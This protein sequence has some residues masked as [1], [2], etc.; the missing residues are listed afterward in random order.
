MM[1]DPAARYIRDL[2]AH[3]DEH[4]ASLRAE[5]EARGFPQIH[6]RPEEGLLLHFLLRSAG[7]RRVVEIGTL[8]GYSA[9]WIARALPADGHLISLERNPEHAA[10]ARE[11]LARA[12]LDG[13][14]EIRL[15]MALDLLQTLSAEGPFDAVFLDADRKNYLA[16]LSWVLDNLR[17]GG[18][19]LAHN[20]FMRG[21]IFDPS[22]HSDPEVKGMLEFTRR[23]AEDPRLVSL[24]IPMGD[25][26]VAALRIEA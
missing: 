5:S 8:A 23:I 10:L 1:D 17:V 2:F 3:D 9:T 18:L 15:G 6:L 24:V 13:R 11:Y 21:R 25:G 26:F 16:Y 22:L 20:A 19:I 14:V 4:L 7:V 12:G